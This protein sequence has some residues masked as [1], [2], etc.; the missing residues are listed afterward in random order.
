MTDTK[1]NKGRLLAF[2]EKY[3]LK[4]LI[5]AVKWES[6]GEQLSTN[7]ISAD[8]TLLG[9][10]SF[11]D[12]SLPETKLGVYSTSQLKSMLGVLQDQV[13]VMVVSRNGRDVSLKVADSKNHINFMLAD[14][15]VIADPPELKTLPEWDV[16]IN[17]DSEFSSLF[18]KS[19][20]ALPEEGKTFTVIEDDG[21]LI[22]VLGHSKNNSSRITINV[23]GSS[24]GEFDPISFKSEYLLNVLKA[25][26]EVPEGT[27]Y[28]STQGISYVAFE[29]SDFKSEYYMVTLSGDS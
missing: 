3:N 14:L 20:R 19:V 15:N 12:V 8:K 26:S 22:V 10:V 23:S 24:K 16:Q 25:N 4:G 17:F 1:M 9:I 11:K 27:L 6:D 21:N 18:E 29:A 13:N 2:I 7:F 5:E 28:I